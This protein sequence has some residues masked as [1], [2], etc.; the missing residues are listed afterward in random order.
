MQSR[1]PQLIVLQQSPFCNIDCQY[2]YLPHRAKKTKMPLKVLEAAY[3]SVFESE[4]M[5]DP[6]SFLWHAGEPLTVGHDYFRKAFA[7]CKSVNQDYGRRFSQNIQTNAMLIDDR[8]V[9]I[10]KQFDVQLGVSLDGPPH[11]HDAQRVDRAGRGTYERVMKGIH[12]L[13]NNNIPFQT[14]TVLTSAS[15]GYPDEIFWHFVEN[16]IHH[17][18]FN[19]DELEGTH[20]T[21]SYS[22][23]DAI[24]R[25]QHFMRR[26]LELMT[27]HPGHIQV[28]EFNSIMPLFIDTQDVINSGMVFNNTNVPLQILTIDFE[29][30]YSTFCPELRSA[31]SAEYNNFKMGNVLFDPI[32]TIYEH[33]TFQ[34]VNT[35]IQAGVAACQ[36]TC[37][38]WELCG[39]GSPSNKFYEHG[40]LNATETIHCKVHIQSL[41]DVIIDFVS[42]EIVG[43]EHA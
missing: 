27:D 9:D 23:G 5:G 38:Y 1:R 42:Q 24:I 10:F 4:I 26:F 36:A 31:Q 35:E 15:L 28:R 19:I 7:L 18:A 43:N 11:I 17:I 20:T 32:D 16:N 33:P 30:N 40:K 41:A 12:K 29:G 34:R 21:T 39:G 25:Y 13:Q 8:W 6:I 3:R 2:C 37:E 22:E 14:I